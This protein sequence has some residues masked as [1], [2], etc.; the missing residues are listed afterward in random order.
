LDLN[1]SV[2]INFKSDYLPLNRMASPG[3]AERIRANTLNPEAEAAAARATR[4]NN[5]RTGEAARMD[6]LNQDLTPTEPARVAPGEPGSVEHADSLRENRAQ[7]PNRSIGGQQKQP[8]PQQP[9][10]QGQPPVQRQ[11]AQNQ[12]QA[13]RQQTGTP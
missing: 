3:Q 8:P 10:A 12:Q 6:R 11:P 2:E 7:A 1:S 4:V 5:A 13:P 9:P